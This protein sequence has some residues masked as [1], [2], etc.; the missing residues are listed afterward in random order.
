[1]FF[2][3]TSQLRQPN[4]EVVDFDENL[5]KIAKEMLLVMYAADG[6]GLAAPQ[7]GINKRVMV[8]NEI[9]I[10]P[11]E[12]KLKLSKSNNSNIDSSLAE[13]SEMVLIN[14]K[15]VN[16]SEGDEVISEEGCLSFPFV[17][18]DVVRYEWIDVEFQTVTAEKRQCR[19]E[20]E[21]SV[22]FQ[23]EYDHLEQKLFIDRFN[24]AD[25]KKNERRLLKYI[26]AFGPD[27]APVQPASS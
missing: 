10:S 1:M 12:F 24:A 23:H 9:G 20:G 21:P 26:R 27:G 6:I 15:I 19:L 3:I 14:P 5:S 4:T 7:V 18:G 8:F 13:K 11:D 16:V 17:H 2:Y 22:I 25:R